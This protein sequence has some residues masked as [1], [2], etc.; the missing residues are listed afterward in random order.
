[1]PLTKAH[2]GESWEIGRRRVQAQD[3]AGS[4][5]KFGGARSD[6]IAVLNGAIGAIGAVILLV[7]GLQVVSGDMTVGQLIAFYAVGGL[8]MR[9][10][11]VASSLAN[12]YASAESLRQLE[13]LLDAHS[14][15]PY[16]GTVVHEP[17]GAVEM[18]GVTFGYGAEPVL[19]DVNLGISSGEH[20]ALLGP[21]GSGKSTIVNLLIGLYA[22]SEGEIT[23]DGVPLREIDVRAF[24]RSIGIVL[25]DPI[26]LPGTI[27]ENIAYSREAPAREEIAAAAEAAT[28]AGFI[29]A[30]PNAY[31]TQVGEEGARLSGGQRQRIAIAR[32][33]FGSPSLLI[34]DEP[35]TYLDHAAIMELLETLNGLPN[36]PTVLLVT[37]DPAV[38]AR[39]DRVVHLRD[40]RVEHI[41]AG[42]ELRA[43]GELMPLPD[44]RKVKR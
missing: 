34:L 31:E 3:L 14:A 4:A 42:H 2:G 16:R 23:M 37:H 5:A 35:T 6:Y 1:M 43:S 9:Q 29:D 22:P 39:A 19:I 18:T 38:A 24:R 21:N 41:E 7:G 15:E 32:A 17:R 40:G 20:I 13:E 11:A 10:V 30:L 28:A 26:I 33:L 25:Q 8:A 44:A 12:A 27:A 36:G